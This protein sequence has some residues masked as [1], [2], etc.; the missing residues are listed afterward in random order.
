MGTRYRPIKKYG[1]TFVIALIP[2]DIE[3]LNL[4]IGDMIDIEDAVRKTSID[5][6]TFNKFRGKKK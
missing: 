4:K 2:K 1:N 5:Q 3:D 6:I